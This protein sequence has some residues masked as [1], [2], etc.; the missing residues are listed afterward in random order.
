MKYF[1][2][3]GGSRGIG[4]EFIKNLSKNDK[5]TILLLSRTSVDIEKSNIIH[6]KTDLLKKKDIVNTIE[7]IKKL[8]YKIDSVFFCQKYRIIAK[9]QYSLKDDFSINV[10][11]T[12]NII[13]LIK[14]SFNQKGLKSIVVVGSIASK[15]VAT[16]QPVDYHISKSAL[17]GLVNFYAVELGILG[18]RINMV[19]P[20]TVIKDENKKFYKNNKSLYH[21]YKDISPLNDVV[22]VKDVINLVK[23]LLSKKSRFI[24]GQNI[25]IDGGISLQWQEVLSRRFSNIDNLKITQ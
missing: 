19:S 3:V 14:E 12:K 2:V 20:S 21:I 25:I 8:E 10:E 23:Y 15:F 4:R 5:N 7:K 1:I 11:A 17:I 18:V 13:E 16:E 22:K 9:E 6:F 24:T